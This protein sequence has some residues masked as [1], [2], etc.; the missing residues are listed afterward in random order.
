[1]NVLRRRGNAATQLRRILGRKTL[2]P[3]ESALQE[4]NP[5]LK[6]VLFQ[7]YAHT[8]M[9]NEMAVRKHTRNGGYRDKRVSALADLNRHIKENIV[10][11]KTNQAI[12]LKNSV[13]EKHYRLS[14]KVFCSFRNV[15]GRVYSRIENTESPTRFLINGRYLFVA[16]PENFDLVDR[17]DIH[18]YVPL[19]SSLI[20]EL[21]NQEFAV[22]KCRAIDKHS[23]GEREVYMVWNRS[24]GRTFFSHSY[25]AAVKKAEE[26][27]K[28][29]FLR[30]AGVQ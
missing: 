9:L 6:K 3:L 12:V 2:R 17:C 14:R 27:F 19:D 30:R 21:H 28:R 24:S 7:L 16:K 25:K 26:E 23:K 22:Y 8:N 1:M 29:L 10:N 20:E 5:Y 11:L 15:L 13:T 4:E 18:R